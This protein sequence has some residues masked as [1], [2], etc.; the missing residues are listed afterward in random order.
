[1]DRPAKDLDTLG[2]SRPP[3]RGEVGVS[4]DLCIR[5]AVGAAVVIVA[6]HL[7]R[8]V[9]IYGLEIN[10]FGYLLGRFDLN[11]EGVVP[12]WFSSLLL[13]SCSAVALAIALMKV[14]VGDR[15]R[16]HWLLMSLLLIYLSADEGAEIHELWRHYLDPR[17]NWTGM[18]Y[19]PAT[20][21]NAI[22]AAAVGLLM[23]PF[24][25][26]LGRET[27]LGLILAGSL[28]VGGAVG[29]EILG[30]LQHSASGTENLRYQLL[31]ALE[32]SLEMAG[33]FVLLSTL[34]A[35]LRGWTDR[36]R[37]VLQA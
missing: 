10:R 31:V 13:A 26:S 35:Y 1:M 21:P 23:A 5:L 3:V 16:L 32:E 34:L 17:A 28:Y 30:G 12:S 27:V 11:G 6:M 20:L 36:P 7:V 4:V 37:L 29:A 2:A 18:L 33:V 9:M 22:G 14:Q 15:Y 24:A 19:Y 25:L 8:A